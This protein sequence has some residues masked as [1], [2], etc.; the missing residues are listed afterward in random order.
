[1][2]TAPTDEPTLQRPLRLWPGV[3]I[4]ALQSLAFFVVPLVVPDATIFAAL[5]GLVGGLAVV[6]W[7]V[8]FSRAA[9][10]ERLGAV[11]LV[12]I[13][14]VATSRLIHESIAT[15]MMGN[16]FLIFAI[17]VLSLAFVVGVVA[18]RRLSDGPRR[19]TMA[20]A[21]LLA[22]GAPSAAA[23]GSA[24]RSSPISCAPS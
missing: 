19:A 18:G 22:C 14:A 20:V 8:F 10:S 6:V 4:V 23:A 24:R 2:T 9:W 12:I 13:A 5:G 7:W 1:M 3:A 11:V 17:P 16:M 21:V 15:T